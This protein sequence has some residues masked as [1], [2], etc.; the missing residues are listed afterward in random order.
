M[1][2]IYTDEV[3]TYNQYQKT[4]E[5]FMRFGYSLNGEHLRNDRKYTE[6]LKTDLPKNLSE[7]GCFVC[8]DAEFVR[9]ELVMF[10]N[11]K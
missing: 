1:T 4:K 8:G 7:F 5:E 3:K 9:R 11:G 2:T 6:F 10:L